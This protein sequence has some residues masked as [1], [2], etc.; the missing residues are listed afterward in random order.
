M[1]DALEIV[2]ST[3][4]V[5]DALARL[6][7]NTPLLGEGNGGFASLSFDDMPI[8]VGL[9]KSFIFACTLDLLSLS[10]TGG[11]PMTRG[12][13][14]DI[15]PEKDCVFGDGPGLRGKAALAADVAASRPPIVLEDGM[16]ELAEV[17]GGL[18]MAGEGARLG[19]V[20]LIGARP[21]TDRF[22]SV[23]AP[24]WLIAAAA[25]I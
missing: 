19:A 9:E 18:V 10:G 8:F 3:R 7:L 17:S 22:R 16:P 6:G 14:G 4:L 12:G 21:G 2:E 25:A 15:V 13:G 11:G 1:D 20:V 23:G 24:R 5:V